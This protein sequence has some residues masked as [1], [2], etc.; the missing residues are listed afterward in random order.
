M[1]AERWRW[2]VLSPYRGVFEM[3]LFGD[4]ALVYATWL[5]R[6]VRLA[7]ADFGKFIED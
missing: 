5:E 2:K 1:V 4:E 6:R 7:F 3:F